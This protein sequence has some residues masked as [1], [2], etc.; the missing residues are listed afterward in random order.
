MEV[1]SELIAALEPV[2][3]TILALPGVVGVG[4]GLREEND[5]LFD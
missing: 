4:I 2:K 5:M 3:W 1:P